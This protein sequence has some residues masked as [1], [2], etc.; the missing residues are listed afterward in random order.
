MNYQ[1]P[2]LPG[3]Y[4]DP[5]VCRVGEDYYLVTS[6][7]EYFPGVP[8]FHSRNLVN[9]SQIGHCLTRKSQLNLEGA[10]SSGGIYAPT[11]RHHAGKFYVVTTDTTGL[12]NFY[13]RADHPA[14]PWSEPVAVKQ[15]GIDPSLFFDASGKVYLS[16]NCLFGD[17]RGLQ[18]SEIDIETGA[19][20]CEPRF[21]WEGTGGKYPEA[22]HLYFR[23]GWYYLL[24]AEG[25]T[26]L[27]HMVTV[28][29]SPEAFGPFE[30]CPH[31][32]ILSHRSTS[33]SIQS[34][35]HGDLIQDHLDGWWMVFLGVRHNSYPLVHHL[36]RETFLAPVTWSDDGWPVINGGKPVSL[37]METASALVAEPQRHPPV[38]TDFTGDALELYWNFRRNPAEGSWSLQDR[39]GW[40]GLRCLP[41][42]LDD[43][44]S[45]AFI[46]RRQQ[47]FSCTAAARLEFAPAGDNEEAGLTVLMNESYRCDL[48]VSRREGEKSVCLRRRLGSVTVE[49]ASRA[50][51][52]GAV[53]LWIKADRDWYE[54]GFTPE[55]RND[56]GNAPA[57]LGRA[58]TRHLS[59]EIA[60]GFTGV[61]FGLYATSNH[62][63][64]QSCAWF[65]WFEY[66]PAHLT[67]DEPIVL[68]PVTAKPKVA[69]P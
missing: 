51:G 4:P 10:K 42:S 63:A 12:G 59:T 28:A 33:Q 18:Q 31:N 58:E 24:V 27:G 35:G 68:Q 6:S 54:L 5:S 13:V 20:R 22:P 29:R 62:A 69:G 49:L 43:V 21:L 52:E 37:A 2:I 38:R 25:G 23:N 66:R 64:S 19:L 15:G 17:R 47:H 48:F 60:G 9:W 56:Q 50:V 57:A 30:P 55:E 67:G 34:T 44:A 16:S 36:G 1:N 11:I 61:Y 46:G 32:P 3:F 65:D 14:G 40:L 39:R 7:F 8:V 41:A 53:V 26:E 45:L